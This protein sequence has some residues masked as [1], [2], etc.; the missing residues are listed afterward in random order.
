MILLVPRSQIKS[1][2]DSFFAA[3]PPRL[4]NRLA[5]YLEIF[6]SNLL[7]FTGFRSL[8][9]RLL[10]YSVFDGWWMHVYMYICIHVHVHTCVCVYLYRHLYISVCTYT[11]ISCNLFILFIWIL[12]CILSTLSVCSGWH[13]M[14]FKRAIQKLDSTTETFYTCKTVI[15]G[16]L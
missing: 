8:W 3:A 4:W 5:S 14:S 6:K 1:K 11:W 2:G 16:I 13:L 15:F 10:V 9:N 12:S 7:V